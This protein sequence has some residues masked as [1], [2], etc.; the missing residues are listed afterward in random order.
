MKVSGSSLVKWRSNI[1]IGDKC[2]CFA[3]VGW[4]RIRG[5]LGGRPTVRGVG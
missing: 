4:Q 2:V 5:R 3:C 1:V